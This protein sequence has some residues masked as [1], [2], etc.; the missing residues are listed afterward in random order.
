ML[1]FGVNIQSPADT[2]RKVSVDY[3]FNSIVH[4]KQ[5]LEAKVRQL[6]IIRDLD[7]RQ[8]SALKKE[9]PYIVCAAFNPPYRKT[10][11]FAYTEYFILDLDHIEA[12]GGSI[13][14]LRESLQKDARVLLSFTSPGEDGIKVLYRL[15][16]RCYD[17]GI[18]SLFYK[19]FCKQFAAENH[20]EGILDL[21]TSDV[22]RACF[23]STDSSAFYNPNAEAVSLDDYIDTQDVFS[24]FEMK[25]EM[26]KIQKNEISNGNKN[27]NSADPEQETMDKI[28]SVLSGKP[29]HAKN[30]IIVPKELD[31]I[32]DGL[33][34]LIQDN[35]ITV[36]AI[37][38][39]QYGK[40][41]KMQ[42]GLK[43]AELNVF[44]GKKGFTVVICPRTGTNAGLNALSAALVKDYLNELT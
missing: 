44:F 21:R 31:V 28:R 8:Y 14:I 2:L 18:Y 24:M 26:D 1:S 16:E 38:N 6:R 40:N 20:L 27:S 4:P 19:A 17:S 36:T 3:L 42:L 37:S 22:C 32:M 11:N 35:G 39:I 41:I 25:R 34:K 10:E 9:L 13:P 43:K 12:S 23:I 33:S 29:N 5:S 7:T 30:D 15:K